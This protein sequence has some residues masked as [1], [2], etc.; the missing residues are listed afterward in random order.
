MAFQL[1]FYHDMA[2]TEIAEIMD[3]PIN[4]IK[5]RLFHARKR[6]AVLLDGQLEDRP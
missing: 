3:C 5:T 2:Y 1:T 4:T 6:L